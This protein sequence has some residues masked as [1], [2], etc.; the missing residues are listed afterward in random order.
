MA[1]NEEHQHIRPGK[2]ILNPRG[3]T[4][5]RSQASLA[6][7]P[8]A[9]GAPYAATKSIPS[10]G[11]IVRST[12][13]PLASSQIGTF[14][15]SHATCSTSDV[16]QQVSSSRQ[17][18]SASVSTAAGG[19]S[20]RL[21]AS[22]GG[23]GSAH[24]TTPTPKSDFGPAPRLFSSFS[25]VGTTKTQPKNSPLPPAKVAPP[26][27]HQARPTRPKESSA[28][29][30][31]NDKTDQRTGS[32]AASTTVSAKGRL[33]QLDRSAADAPVGAQTATNARASMLCYYLLGFFLLVL[34]AILVVLVQIRSNSGKKE[35]WW[36][37]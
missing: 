18:P 29:G 8:A 15:S 11:T 31:Y 22:G 17:E 27:A 16:A 37:G 3:P 12:S 24:N 35:R 5:Q 28:T 13:A 20:D 26:S 4:S 34:V 6:I 19:P 25:N 1:V 36:S 33:Q 7:T 30:G 21:G 14:Q 23:G 2:Q 10:L 32:T 9:L